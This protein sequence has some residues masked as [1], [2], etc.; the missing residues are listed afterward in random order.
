MLLGRRQT[1]KRPVDYAERLRVTDEALRF[2]RVDSRGNTLLKERESDPDPRDT[3]PIYPSFAV[4]QLYLLNDRAYGVN[5]VR[6]PL[7]FE[8]GSKKIDYN[9]SVVGASSLVR[10]L[11]NLSRRLGEIGSGD[12]AAALRA[13]PELAV[14][15]RDVYLLLRAAILTRLDALRFAVLTNRLLDYVFTQA[16]PVESLRQISAL[17]RDAAEYRTKAKAGQLNRTERAQ[18]AGDLATRTIRSIMPAVLQSAADN[19]DFA[20]AGST[21]DIIVPRTP[22]RVQSPRRRTTVQIEDDDDEIELSEPPPL[23]VDPSV[24]DELNALND[25]VVDDNEDDSL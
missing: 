22:R 1:V 10:Q 3:G 11:T 6:R 25:T 13:V 7:V 2:V 20:A 17:Q 21:G 12:T 4:L 24:A 8:Q 14:N 5:I 18:I 16:L 19:A 9:S 23:Q 15:N